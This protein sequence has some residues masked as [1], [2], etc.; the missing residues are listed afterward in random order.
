[1]DTRWL[2]TVLTI[3]TALNIF[4]FSADAAPAQ[5]TLC[6]PPRHA[7]LA[8]DQRDNWREDC[9]KKRKATLTFNQCMAIASSMEYSNNAEDARMVCLYDLS[10]TL[11]LKECAQVAKSMEYADSGD[12]ARWECIR[13]NNTTISKNQCLKLAKAMSYPANV[14]RAGQYCT[15]ELK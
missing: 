5:G 12:E 8:M 3:L 4:A 9:L 2:T 14:Q 7:K 10:K 6:Q 15:Q 1:M 11:S 13:K